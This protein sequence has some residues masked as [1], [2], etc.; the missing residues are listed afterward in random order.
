MKTTETVP[1]G[2]GATV[3][4]V[5]REQPGIHFRALERAA[6]LSSAGQ[7]RHHLDQLS[8][9]GHLVEVRDGGYSRFFIANDHDRHIRPLLA[10][11]ARPVP[12]RIAK[13]LLRG[14]MTRTDIRKALACADST[15]GYYLARM[16][17]QGDLVKIQHAGSTEYDLA[18]PEAVRKVFDIQPDTPDGRSIARV[19]PP[20]ERRARAE[21][22]RDARIAKEQAEQH[23]VPPEAWLTAQRRD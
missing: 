12:R 20:A 22:R 23:G 21:A 7:L 14:R 8:R 10:R 13:L 15:L 3:H 6:G 19:L 17:R 11:F 5:I 4:R 1:E 2:V 18:D 16:H 9:R